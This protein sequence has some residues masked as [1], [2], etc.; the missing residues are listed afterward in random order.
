MA[1]DQKITFQELIQHLAYNDIEHETLTIKFDK[2]FFVDEF[3]TGLSCPPFP[4]G[5]CPPGYEKECREN[6]TWCV[7]KPDKR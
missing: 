3:N 4:T 5:A 2:R 7:W 6:E 1:K